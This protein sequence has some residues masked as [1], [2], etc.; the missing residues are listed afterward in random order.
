MRGHSD[1]RFPRR[2]V[3]LQALVHTDM[4]AAFAAYPKTWGLKHP[5]FKYRPSRV[6]NL[7]TFFTRAGAAQPLNQDPALYLPG[8]VVSWRIPAPHIG[9]VSTQR[10]ASGRPLMAHNVGAGS[11]LEDVLF[12]WPIKGWFRYRPA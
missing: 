12:V 7:E 10:H 4:K 1:P 6:P 11:Q 5:D 9:V 3:D 8:D 2:R